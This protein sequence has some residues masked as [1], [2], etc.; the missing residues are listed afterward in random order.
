MRVSIFVEGVRKL[1]RRRGEI[2]LERL[3]DV[4]EG[5]QEL[6]NIASTPLRKS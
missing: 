1:E 6:G 3:K 4:I 2:W 5:A